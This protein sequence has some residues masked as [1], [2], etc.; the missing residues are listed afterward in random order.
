N[1]DNS[2]VQPAEFKPFSFIYNT[3]ERV[4]ICPTC[5][6]IVLDIWRH[7]KRGEHKI[8]GEAIKADKEQIKAFRKKLVEL[9][10]ASDTPTMAPSMDPRPFIAG[11][12][13]MWAFPCT[14]CTFARKERRHTADHVK[15]KPCHPAAAVGAE[16]IQVQRPYNTFFVRV[17]LPPSTTN[18][19]LSSFLHFES[20]QA[21]APKEEPIDTRF[22]SPLL[23]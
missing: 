12:S 6:C 11:L 22:V 16:R 17:A 10:A 23:L 18:P 2:L 1:Y 3:V 21:S 20:A 5:D 14:H 13:V 9:G 4:V 15:F 8:K 19:V 7:L